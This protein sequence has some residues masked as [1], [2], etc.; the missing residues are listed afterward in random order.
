MAERCAAKF[1]FLRRHSAGSITMELCLL[2]GLAG[3]AITGVM[4]ML[5]RHLDAMFLDIAARLATLP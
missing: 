1:A 3:T 2:M 4:M 5:S